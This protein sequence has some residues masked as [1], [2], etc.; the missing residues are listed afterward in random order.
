M[1]RHVK[2][3]ERC[4]SCAT[5]A[6]CIGVIRSFAYPV[7]RLHMGVERAAVRAT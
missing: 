7:H 4:A 1:L 2:D 5:R 6:R 3:T